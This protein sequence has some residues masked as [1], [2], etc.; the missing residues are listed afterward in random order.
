MDAAFLISESTY[1]RVAHIVT[2]GKQAEVE[3]RGRD[4]V[5]RVYEIL[6]AVH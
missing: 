4:Q 2:T 6:G 1:D 5:L 3:I